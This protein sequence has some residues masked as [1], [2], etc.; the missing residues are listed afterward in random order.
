MWKIFNIESTETNTKFGINEGHESVSYNRFLN[1][2]KGSED[3]RNFY[4]SALAD[5]N[6]EAFFWENKPVTHQTLNDKYQPD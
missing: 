5:S 6:F 4:N 2:L 3:F 1:L